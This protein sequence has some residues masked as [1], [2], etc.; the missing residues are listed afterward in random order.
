MYSKQLTL[1]AIVTFMAAA[2]V[3]CQKKVATQN[4]DS[5]M[6]A[7]MASAK[8]SATKQQPVVPLGVAGNF[9]ILSESGITDVYKSAIT[10]NIGSSPITGAAI[11]VTCS[12]VTGT[13]YAADS[14]GPLPCAVKDATM[15]TAAIGAMQTAYTNAAGR[16]NPDFTNLGAGSIGGQT[17]TP[18]LY[19]WTSPV[20][21]PTNITISGGPNDVWI[22]QIAGTLKMSAAVKIILQGGAQAQNIYWQVAGD[23][24]VGAGS[25]FEGTILGQTAINLLTGASINGTMLSQTAVTLQM[26]TVTQP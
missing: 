22:F 3:G 17:L 7:E 25:H 21:I 19:K 18:G 9:A 26:N 12:E 14:A 1:P 23:V 16:S 8:G 10:G 2:A 13:I 11:L 20:L 15:L 4:M 24:T 5:T 6:A